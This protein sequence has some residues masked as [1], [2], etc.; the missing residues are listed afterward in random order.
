MTSYP[1]FKCVLFLKKVFVLALLFH[2][3]GD[4]IFFAIDFNCFRFKSLK[5]LYK[6]SSAL[7]VY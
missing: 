6:V 7:T 4:L 5:V 2:I 1:R 3:V